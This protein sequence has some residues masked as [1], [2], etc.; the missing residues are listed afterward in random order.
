MEAKLVVE[1]PGAERVAIAAPRTSGAA[2]TEVRSFE[3]ARAG[4]AFLVS[5]C[6]STPVPGWVEDMRPPVM[7]RAHAWTARIA[8]KATAAPVELHGDGDERSVH[9]VAG[10]GASVGIARTVVGFEEIGGASRV[11]T[12]GIACAVRRTTAGD[13]LACAGAVRS[14]HLAGDVAPPPPGVVLAG[15]S[16]AVHH[17]SPATSGLVALVAFGLVVAV[18]ARRR[19]RFRG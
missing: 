8:E 10:D 16:W 19:P 4:D 13:A 2:G 15:V 1:A 6:V 17:P 5:G 7:A 12:C 11:V 9:L 3:A 14:A 18:V